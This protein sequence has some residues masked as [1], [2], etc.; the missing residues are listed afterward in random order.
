MKVLRYARTLF[1]VTTGIIVSWTRRHSRSRHIPVKVVDRLSLG[2]PNGAVW[3]RFGGE[4]NNNN[5]NNK[6]RQSTEYAPSRHRRRVDI[7]TRTNPSICAH[8]IFLL[9]LLWQIDAAPLHFRDPRPEHCTYY[10]H[11]VVVLHYVRSEPRYS[12]CTR[13]VNGS[14]A[15]RVG[16]LGR[17][18][19]KGKDSY[20][21]GTDHLLRRAEFKPI[22]AAF[23]WAK[24]Y[25]KKI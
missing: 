5:N 2:N 15:I 10:Y 3:P 24:N 9:L 8:N 22:Q 1:A 17:G 16:I 12:R 6:N 19:W 14:A 4:K 20:P 23:L 7:R 25:M 18:E 11:I 13:H 21:K